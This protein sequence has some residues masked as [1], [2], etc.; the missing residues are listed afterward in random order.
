MA[1]RTRLTERLGIEHP[2]LLAPMGN[3]S[4]GALAALVPDHL[5]TSDHSVLYDENGLPK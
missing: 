3:V 5:R 4:G 1:I 2:I